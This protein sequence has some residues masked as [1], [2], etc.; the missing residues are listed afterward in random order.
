MVWIYR[1]TERGL[2]RNSSKLCIRAKH[3]RMISEFQVRS[4]QVLN[5][6]SS[7]RLSIQNRIGVI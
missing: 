6:I 7:E 4:M 5:S 1:Y 3:E 2:I